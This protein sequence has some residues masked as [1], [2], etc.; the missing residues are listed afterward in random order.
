MVKP[1][2][3]PKKKVATKRVAAKGHSKEESAKKKVVHHV[4]PRSTK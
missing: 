3:A 2:G 4:K 1:A